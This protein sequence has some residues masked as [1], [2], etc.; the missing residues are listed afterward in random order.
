MLVYVY[1]FNAHGLNFSS[2]QKMLS[3]SVF[4]EYSVNRPIYGEKAHVEAVIR[5]KTN[6]AQHGYLTIAVK[7]ELISSE[8][9]KDALGNPLIK[10]KEGG[11]KIERL[12]CFF[13]HNHEYV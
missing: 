12:I 5:N 3:P 8:S 10:V 7:K 9:S 2:W 11:L 4:Y 1:L 13:H 6:K